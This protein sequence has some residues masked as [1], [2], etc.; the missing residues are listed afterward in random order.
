MYFS[1]SEKR[2]EQSIQIGKSIFE[3]KFDIKETK[4]IL[5]MNHILQRDAINCG[6]FVCFYGFQIMK[7]ETFA[8][9]LIFLLRRLK[10]KTLLM[11]TETR[12]KYTV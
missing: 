2:A 10:V 9:H 5:N 12:I 4:V 11:S 6:V 8:S 1:Q 3:R 7:G